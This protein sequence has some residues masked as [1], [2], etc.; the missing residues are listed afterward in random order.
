MKIEINNNSYT[1][2]LIP[3]V[4]EYSSVEGCNGK[5]RERILYTW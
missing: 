1:I 3:N 4:V 2:L 5:K